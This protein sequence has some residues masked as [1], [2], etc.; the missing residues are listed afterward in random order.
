M[1]RGQAVRDS[2]R[3]SVDAGLESQE[4]R[5]IPRA[6][7]VP[8][9]ED[10]VRVEIWTSVAVHVHPHLDDAHEL[11]E[12]N[13]VLTVAISHSDGP[14]PRGSRRCSFGETD[15]VVAVL[16]DPTARVGNDERTAVA[17]FDC[18][19]AQWPESVACGVA[20]DRRYPMGGHH[21]SDRSRGEML[22]AA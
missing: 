17:Q 16:V 2:F 22:V 7:R 12:V 5:A 3:G 21:G 1:L 19:R 14:C 11:Q 6:G 20:A 10:A 4:D 9:E 15:K 8:K 13:R 18:Q